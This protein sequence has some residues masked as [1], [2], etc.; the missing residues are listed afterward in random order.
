MLI[1]TI[2]ATIRKYSLISR[3]ET[4]IAGVSGGP[5]STALLLSLCALKKELGFSLRVA[6]MNHMT[7][8]GSCVDARFVTQL[9]C[10]LGVPCTVGEP[11]CDPGTQHGSSEERWRAERLT[12]FSQVARDAKTH[13][14][15]LAHTRDDQV[16]TV[17]MRIIRGTGLYGLAGMI[18]KREIDGLIVIRPLLEVSRADVESY[19]GRRRVSAR[20]DPTNTQDAFFRNKIRNRLLPLLEKGYNPGIRDSLARLGESA[21]H[22]YDFLLQCASHVCGRWQRRLSIKEL[23]KTHPAL[24]RVAF[25]KAI[26]ATA[27]STRRITLKHVFEIEDLLLRRPHGSIVDLPKGLSCVKRRTHLVFSLA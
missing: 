27:G 26:A 18:P 23:M 16:E 17:L 11:C 12:F 24:R 25:R 7:R 21:G 9:S 1:D 19:L 3:G 5:D 10:K 4:I 20:T 22:D 2:R 15:A 8:K 13:V 6:H 14:V